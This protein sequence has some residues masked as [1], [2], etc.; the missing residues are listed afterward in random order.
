MYSWAQ[1]FS[2]RKH[3]VSARVVLGVRR[4][5][6]LNQ[7]GSG[8]SLE[9][10]FG[11]GYGVRFGKSSVQS[12]VYQIYT[13]QALQL[14]PPGRQYTENFAARFVAF[15]VNLKVGYSWGY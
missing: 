6:P 7:R 13:C 3:E 9:F 10:S 5:L 15:P 8:L 4:H 12:R 1:A 11:A 2:L 14:S